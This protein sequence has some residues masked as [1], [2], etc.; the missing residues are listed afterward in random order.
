MHFYVTWKTSHLDPLLHPAHLK[1]YATQ[2][3]KWSN[4][5]EL[6]GMFG[7]QLA[8]HA[9]C[10]V[11]VAIAVKVRIFILTTT[12]ID[13]AASASIPAS[14]TTSIVI[15]ARCTTPSA[16]CVRLDANGV[17]ARHAMFGCKPGIL[18][19]YFGLLL[20]NYHQTTTWTYC[21][22]QGLLMM[23]SEYKF[24]KG[25][26]AFY[27]LICVLGGPHKL[28][29]GIKILEHQHTRAIHTTS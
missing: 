29:G 28:C 16:F 2:E 8:I 11:S 13:I 14:T 26:P 17:A 20:W 9:A 1:P 10:P 22:E 24:L 25:N 6:C 12:D 7:L 21:I 18:A 4:R 19:C 3:R 23:V 5:I 15:T 27:E